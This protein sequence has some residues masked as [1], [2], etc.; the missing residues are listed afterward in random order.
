MQTA[1]CAHFGN[2]DFVIYSSFHLSVIQTGTTVKSVTSKVKE[3]RIASISVQQIIP[4][5]S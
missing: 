5:K 2:S 1:I 4:E 3:K